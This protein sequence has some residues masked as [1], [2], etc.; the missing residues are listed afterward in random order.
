MHVVANTA[1]DKSARR[2]QHCNEK[3]HVVGNTATRSARR[4]QPCNEKRT[5]SP[6][7]AAAGLEEAAWEHRVRTP[8]CHEAQVEGPAQR[9]SAYAPRT[10]R[11]FW[12]H[13]PRCGH[14]RL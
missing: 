4:R 10:S 3:L 12:Q 13:Q 6:T 11:R 2:A 14:C 8:G 9:R 7:H 1:R 5:S